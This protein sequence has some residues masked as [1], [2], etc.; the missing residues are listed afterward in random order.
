MWGLHLCV[1]AQSPAFPRPPRDFA[2][3]A[4]ETGSNQARKDH[5]LN[6]LKASQEFHVLDS[7]KDSILKWLHELAWP[8]EQPKDPSKYWGIADIELVSRCSTRVDPQEAWR[9]GHVIRT[10]CGE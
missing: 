10:F 5:I 9:P 7:M 3:F 2:P 1:V 6:C 4:E 8:D